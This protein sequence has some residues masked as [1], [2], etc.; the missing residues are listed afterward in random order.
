[1]KNEG[2]PEAKTT[3]NIKKHTDIDCHCSKPSLNICQPQRFTKKC[4]L[5]WLTNSALV[6]QPKC[7]GG[8]FVGSQ[9]MSTAV[10]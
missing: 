8:G 1:M 6:Y 2:G 5:Y 9:P 10:H 7:G 3:T 4:H